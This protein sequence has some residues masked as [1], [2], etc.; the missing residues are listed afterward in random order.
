MQDHHPNRLITLLW[1][2]RSA[3]EAKKTENSARGLEHKLGSGTN[4]ELRLWGTVLDWTSQ[5]QQLTTTRIMIFYNN[6]IRY[7]LKELHIKW[8][9]LVSAGLCRFLLVSS[10]DH[11]KTD[12][13]RGWAESKPRLKNSLSVW[14]WNRNLIWAYYGMFHVTVHLTCV[15]FSLCCGCIKSHCSQ[16][17]TQMW[18]TWIHKNNKQSVRKN[19]A[20]THTNACTHTNTNA[21]TH[22][23]QM[24]NTQRYTG[25]STVINLIKLLTNVHL[26]SWIKIKR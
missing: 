6:T 13:T 2:H 5:P 10:S 18:K 7:T 17:K 19:K 1:C 22:T 24:N 26:I 16:K 11:V 25:S 14:F 4:T 15:N 8:Y 21:H 20:H 3:A 12:A 9:Q 23:Q